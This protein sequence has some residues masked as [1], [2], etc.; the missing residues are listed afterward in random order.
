VGN[1]TVTGSVSFV[2][3]GPYDVEVTVALY[4][5]NTNPDG[6]HGIHIH[7]WGDLRGLLTNFGTIGANVTGALSVGSHFDPYGTKL[8]GCPDKT[9][10]ENQGSHGGDLGNWQA[11]GGTIEGVKTFTNFS[12]DGPINS[13]VGRAIVIHAKQD[14]CSDIN[15]SGSRLGFGVIG[16]KWVKPE[17]KNKARA[18]TGFDKAVCVLEGTSECTGNYCDITNTGF[19]YFTQVGKNAIK[20]TAQVWG[21]DSERGWHIHTYGDLSSLNGDSTGGHWNPLNHKHGL[22]GQSELHLG[23][24]GSIKTFSKNPGPFGIYEHTLRHRAT[25]WKIDNIIGRAI[26]IHSDVDHGG[27]ESVCSGSSTSGNSGKRVYQ[28]VIGIVNPVSQKDSA[29][30]LPTICTTEFKFDNNWENIPCEPPY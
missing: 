20:I 15:S 16:I 6:Y 1:N 28:C 11:K 4:N 9:S 8:H 18:G 22:P 5:I 21:L 10:G 24:L 3:T 30:K 7:V 2:Q 12:L 26:I 13:I 23:D 25:E 19:V 29:T 27:D 17:D 14:D